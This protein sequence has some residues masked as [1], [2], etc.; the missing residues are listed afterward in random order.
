VGARR[1]ALPSHSS[2]LDCVLSYGATGDGVETLQA[3]LIYCNNAKYVTL[4]GTYDQK[5]AEAISFIQTASGTK[6]IDG[7]YGPETRAVLNWV[8]HN[9][10]DGTCA[11]YG[12]K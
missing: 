7:V 5:T 8:H 12:E 6:A 9:G 10:T 11:K 2:S 1:V 3:T 4:T